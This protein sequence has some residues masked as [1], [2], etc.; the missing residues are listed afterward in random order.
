VSLDHRNDPGE[1][2]LDWLISMTAMMSCSRVARHLLKSFTCGIGHSVGYVSNRAFFLAAR[3]IASL[4]VAFPTA[5]LA[6]SSASRAVC[7]AFSVDLS[8]MAVLP[9]R[10]DKYCQIQMEVAALRG[11]G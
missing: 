10:D 3:P 7:C 9:A 5:S 4:S 2:Q 6:V 1:S 8:A 11:S